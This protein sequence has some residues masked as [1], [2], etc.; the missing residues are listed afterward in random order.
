MFISEYFNIFKLSKRSFFLSTEEWVINLSCNLLHLFVAK[1][2]RLKKTAIE[3]D[4]NNTF[5][6]RDITVPHQARIWL[7]IMKSTYY[8]TFHFFEIVKNNESQHSD[9]FILS[10]CRF[11]DFKVNDTYL[12]IFGNRSISCPSCIEKILARRCMQTS[13]DHIKMARMAAAT[14]SNAKIVFSLC[15]YIIK[16]IWYIFLIG[17]T[18]ETNWNAFIVY[19]VSVSIKNEQVR[20]RFTIHCAMSG[21]WIN[22]ELKNRKVFC[23]CTVFIESALPYDKYFVFMNALHILIHIT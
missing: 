16:H 6:G 2:L 10:I 12:E 21:Q 19:I 14:K 7:R 20:K 8:N 4:N 11:V 23:I 1:I 13:F 9:S 3:N 15:T 22:N 18:I 17:R 5:R